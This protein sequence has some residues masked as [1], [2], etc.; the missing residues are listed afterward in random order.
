VIYSSGYSND[1]VNRELR[2]SP[3]RT[4]LQKPYRVADL[5]HIVR[6]CLNE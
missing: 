5:A 4:F 1:V 2:R 3:G 6:R